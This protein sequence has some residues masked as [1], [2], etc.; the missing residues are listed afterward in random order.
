MYALVYTVR[1][2]CYIRPI[3][4]DPKRVYFP[5]TYPLERVLLG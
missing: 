5:L 4:E 1:Q 2:L 3:I